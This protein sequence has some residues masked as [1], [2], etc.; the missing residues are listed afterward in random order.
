MEAL[1]NRGSHVEAAFQ[2][3]ELR[4]HW[5]SAIGVPAAEAREPFSRVLAAEP[6]NVEAALHLARIA[7]RGHRLHEFD[8]L[9]APLR[10]VDGGGVWV[11][12]LN[13]LRAFLVG[14][15]AAQQRA[16]DAAGGS[17]DWML[18][19]TAVNSY[20]LAAVERT[21]AARLGLPRDPGGHARTQLFLTQLRLGL[22]RYRDALR[23]IDEA[24]ALPSARRAEY[25][26]MIAGLPFR[27]MTRDELLAVRA[28]T[29][30]Y[31]DTR[32]GEDGVP[33]SARGVEYP[34]VLW[35]GMF[36][37]R[38]LYLL[39]L[40]HSRVGNLDAAAAV[41]DSLAAAA[42][43]EV[44]ARHYERIVRAHIALQ[45]GEQDAALRTLGQPADP[46]HGT[47]ENFVDHGRPYERW[48]RAELLRESGRLA[49]AL[50]WYAT[51]PD[52]AAR[53]LA[54]LAPSHLR[55]AE[56]H[57]AAGHRALAVEHYARF[58][59]LWRE[60]DAELQPEVER[61]RSRLEVLRGR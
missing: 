16:V 27:P 11:Q 53:D 46:I 12:E 28:A 8:S 6:G 58:V 55:R 51:F 48:L 49:E 22:G 52:P 50:Q 5:G 34:H 59:A 10:V 18:E 31:P 61:A 13:L 57:D 37:E 7:A 23:S 45:R 35:P 21:T 20:N 40:L 29:A 17:A 25:R 47:F 14:D 42:P 2:L 9:M 54:F 4:F 30:D 19:S 38:R 26:A 60:A 36:R 32:P 3:G 39:A 24:T 1:H 15:A 33:T 43:T 41:A 56:I 44:F